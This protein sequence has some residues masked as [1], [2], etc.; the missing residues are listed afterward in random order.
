MT[1]HGTDS[2]PSPLEH[3]V[4]IYDRRTAKKNSSV[5]LKQETKGIRRKRKAKYEGQK[6]LEHLEDFL[7]FRKKRGKI[8]N[9][10]DWRKWFEKKRLPTWS[11]SRR[12]EI[13]QLHSGGAV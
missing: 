3:I 7:I 6:H 13:R 11:N 12:E 2:L 9:S 1:N 5:K 8:K 4:P 10:W